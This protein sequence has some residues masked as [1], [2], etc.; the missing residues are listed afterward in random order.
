LAVG[1]AQN[2]L[3]Q[4]RDGRRWLKWVKGTQFDSFVGGLSRHEQLL[5]AMA[6]ADLGRFDEAQLLLVETARY[7]LRDR[8]PVVL[9]D[10]IVALAYMTYRRGEVAGALDLLAP[11][12]RDSRFRLVTMYP[13]VFRFIKEIHAAA[14]AAG[15]A[16]DLPSAA[17]FL[18]TAGRIMAEGWLPDPAFGEEIEARLAAFVSA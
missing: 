1:D 15:L 17:D 5:E 10:C 14:H 2:A 8:Y 3:D 12:V 7:M 4:M 18:A 6:L 16:T 11:A 9:H 13:F